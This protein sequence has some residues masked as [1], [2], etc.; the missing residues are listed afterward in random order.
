MGQKKQQALFRGDYVFFI[1][2]HHLNA[3]ESKTAN[4]LPMGQ[5]CNDLLSCVSS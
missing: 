2:R 5:K 4:V 3:Q 1:V